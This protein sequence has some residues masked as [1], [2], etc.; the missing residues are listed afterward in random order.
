MKENAESYD[1]S[2]PG[3]SK[4]R[5]D[6]D[7]SDSLRR[8]GANKHDSSIATDEEEEEKE[9]GGLAASNGEDTRAAPPGSDDFEATAARKVNYE[10]EFEAIPKV[11]ASF[12]CPFQRG[13]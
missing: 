9:E 11:R 7:A 5:A 4:P 13:F 1:P 8:E 2:A 10:A 12:P 6:V 3:P